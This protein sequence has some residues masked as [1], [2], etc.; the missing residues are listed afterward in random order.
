MLEPIYYEQNN[1]PDYE[2]ESPI[3]GSIKIYHTGK[4]EMDAATVDFYETSLKVKVENIQTSIASFKA[5]SLP[6]EKITQL[7]SIEKEF[8]SILK[9][10]PFTGTG[11]L[12]TSFQLGIRVEKPL[13]KLAQ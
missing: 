12:E 13:Y 4:F 6:P 3:S 5:A 7:Q 8:D 10:F 2:L 1:I 9:S 11:T